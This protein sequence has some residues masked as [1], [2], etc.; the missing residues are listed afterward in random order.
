ML[1]TDRRYEWL[2]TAL[3]GQNLDG[4]QGQGRPYALLLVRGTAVER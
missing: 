1:R 2:D 4:D 3:S